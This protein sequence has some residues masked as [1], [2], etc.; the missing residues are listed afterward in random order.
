[1][2]T[3]SAR[4]A[5]EQNSRLDSAHAAIRLTRYKIHNLKK[6]VF[7]ARQGPTRSVPL[8]M[9]LFFW[10]VEKVQILFPRKGIMSEKLLKFQI[11]S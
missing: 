9:G 10:A 11:A 5:A 7:R 4:F 3:G 6:C 1:L 2:R 8:R